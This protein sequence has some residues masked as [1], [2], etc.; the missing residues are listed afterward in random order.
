MGDTEQTQCQTWRS[1]TL[2]HLQG[3]LRHSP[4]ARNR[5]R[6]CVNET[7]NIT[8]WWNIT[9]LCLMFVSSG[10]CIWA[11]LPEIKRWNGM[12]W[13]LHTVAILLS[14]AFSLDHAHR[15]YRWSDFTLY[16][17]NDVFTRK[18]VPFGGSVRNRRNICPQ[19]SLKVDG[20]GSFKRKREHLKSHYLRTYKSDQDKV[21][22]HRSNRQL[23]FVG[24]VYHYLTANPTWLTA[25]ILKIAVT[26]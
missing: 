16:L 13:K 7:W 4:V 23:H 11:S 9:S 17:S 19:N 20:I 1:I 24:G 3:C 18:D 6:M 2:I 15:S 10:F 12:E 8:H 25:D 22:G 21:W 14:C 5:W 26:S